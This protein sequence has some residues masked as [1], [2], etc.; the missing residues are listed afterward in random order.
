MQAVVEA[1][2]R[3]G[4][5]A[6]PLVVAVVWQSTIV[7]LVVA[8]AVYALRGASPAVRYWLWQ[9]V[10]IKLLVVPL[11]S[12]SLAVG[13]LPAAMPAPQVVEASPPAPS[14]NA[15][16]RAELPRANVEPVS[17][18]TRTHAAALT[19]RGGLFVAWAAIVLLQIARLVWQRVR[20][21]RIL[22]ACEPADLQLAEI[23]DRLGEC[24]GLARRPRLLATD[25]A[26]SPFVCGILQ[27][28]LVVPRELVATLARADLEQVV[29]HELA[30]VARRDLV[31]GW[32]P[33]IAR[34]LYFFHPVAHVA[35]QRI[36]LERELACDQQA[37]L[38]SGRRPGEYAE[39][40]VRV[41]GIASRPSMLGAAAANLSGEQ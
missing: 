2:N 20:L 25:L 22:R 9:I 33:E 23:V 15:S 40:L 7:A 21:A 10:A 37:M 28:A 30:H 1:I 19:W 3:L 27:P 8:A 16:P 12:W 26:S 18:A 41:L 29:A 4:A 13:W 24:L 17:V 14:P 11:W 6:A 32:I 31:W 5:G 36:R 38:T 39:T 34:V 35:C